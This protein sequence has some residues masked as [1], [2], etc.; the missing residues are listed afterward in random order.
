MIIF[1]F[2]TQEEIDDLPDDDPRTAFTNFVRLADRRLNERTE[3]I[4]AS[5]QIGWERL[6][7]ARY[8][9]VNVVI[10]AAKKYDIVPFASHDVPRL[11]Q[12]NA[13]GYLQ[14]RADLDHYLTQLVLDN[15]SQAK[16]ASVL[17]PPDLKTT[18]RTYIF[19]LRELIENSSDLDESK[20]TTLLDRLSEFEAALE[21]KRLNLVAVTVLAITLLSAPGAIWS[22]A[23]AANKILT[24]IFRAVAQAKTAEDATRSLPSSELPMAISGPRQ[25]DQQPLKKP[26]LLQWKSDADDEIPF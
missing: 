22:S 4:D 6:S 15:S 7:E 8:G 21:K 25:N 1:D 24:N 3:Q 9:F 12:F 14:F 10:A 19:H 11:S 26:E 23:D 18:I 5:D 17:I 2:L 13:E 16:R 20:R